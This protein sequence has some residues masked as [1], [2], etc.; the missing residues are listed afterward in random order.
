M[1]TDRID[2]SV[3]IPVYRSSAC[4]PDLLSELTATLDALSRSYEIILV[5][6]A[7]PGET[8][9][10]IQAEAPKYSNVLAVRLMRNSG[11]ARATLCGLAH[12]RGEIIVTM[13]DDLQH[14]PDQLPILL[15]ALAERPDTD[16][17]LARF[18]EK[19]HSWY[20]NLGSSF[21]A[22]VN[23]RAF[24]TPSG[25]RSSGFRA[26]RSQAARAVLAHRTANPA[27]AALLYSSTHHVV[28]VPVRHAPRRSGR[29][30]YTF[31]KQFRLAWD[32]ICNVSMLPLR[33]VSAMGIVS[34]FLSLILVVIIVIRYLRG[35][36]GVAGWATIVTLISFFSGLILVSVGVMGEY[37]VRV[38]REVRQSPMYLERERLGF[39]DDPA[40]NETAGPTG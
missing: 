14:P 36:V 24:G 5:D 21:L 30:G 20:R 2:I 38:L 27:I 33:A 16:C 32:N 6:D 1:D 35:Q 7:S 9:R 37:L 18:D 3:V 12:A 25:V 23:A 31:S 26:M 22:W 28:S 11:Q 10:V 8:W 39:P 17:V 4:M 34:C 15:D 13:D 29:S 40:A 19:E